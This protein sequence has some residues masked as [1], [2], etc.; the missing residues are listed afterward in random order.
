M[1]TANTRSDEPRRERW[2]ALFQQSTRPL[3][4]LYRS[5]RV[6]YVN[7]A[8]EA[9][10]K[11]AAADAIGRAC[12]RSGRVEPVFRTLAP[13]AEARDAVVARVRRPAPGAKGGP[14]W[15]DITFVPLVTADGTAGFFGAIDVVNAVAPIPPRKTPPA[16]GA[17]RDRQAMRF[18]FELFAGESALAQRFQARLRLA[19]KSMEPVWIVG[20]SGSGKETLAR[21][22]HHQSSAREKAFVV[23]ECRGVE[24]YLL[25]GVLF[26]IAGIATAGQVGTLFLKSPAALPRDAQQRI[27]DW[28]RIAPHPP[29]LICAS[30]ESAAASVRAGTLLEDFLAEQSTIELELPPLRERA[31]ELS[32]IVERM[33]FALAAESPVLL[34]VHDWPGNLHELHEILSESALRAGEG[35][36]EP[37]HLPRYIRERAWLANNPMPK[38]RTLSL[39]ALLEAV[40]RRMIESALKRSNGNQTEAATRLGIFRTRLG[41]RIEA[42]KIRT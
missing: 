20:E 22:V 17:I 37:E 33:G 1:S 8:W 12:V 23:C 40:E 21:V 28:L 4:V 7:A 6:Q 13:P 19:A 25:D 27:L 3:F 39:D 10:A 5:R 14:P 38:E 24:P 11:C 41:R 18:S 36:I 32:H 42:L 35:A 26:G 34:A 29:R 16:V 9:L 15:W 31:D 30:A 2:A